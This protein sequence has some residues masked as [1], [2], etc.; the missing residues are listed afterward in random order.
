MLP[1]TWWFRTNGAVAPPTLR[2]ADGPD[3]PRV[4]EVDGGYVKYRK[5]LQTL[6]LRHR[7]DVLLQGISQ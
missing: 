2:L 3:G 6:H 5:E 1:W 7:S 4:V